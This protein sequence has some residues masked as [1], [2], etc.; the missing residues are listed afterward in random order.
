MNGGSVLSIKRLDE[1]DDD[2]YLEEIAKSAK[3]AASAFGE[4]L[5]TNI[6]EKLE[7]EKKENE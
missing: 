1:D 2:R 5:R 7:A 3:P 6:Q 4:I